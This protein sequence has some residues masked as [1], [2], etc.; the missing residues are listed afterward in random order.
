MIART[1]KILS[2]GLFA[3]IL[4]MDVLSKALIVRFLAIGH[5]YYILP[6]FNIVHVRNYGVSFGLL[7]QHQDSGRFILIALTLLIAIWVIGMWIKTRVQLEKH[8]FLCIIA[9]AV[10][11]IID[12]LYFGSVVDFVDLHAF[13]YHWP[14]F[15]VADS[16]IVCG[17]ILLL[18]RE[19]WH[20]CAGKKEL[21]T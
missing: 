5:G 18:G 20:F 14:A 3:G 2:I 19:M 16:A 8:A 21:S 4:G 7:Q 10:G 6:F 1:H 12:R 13:G 9:G 17:V 15:N 11:N